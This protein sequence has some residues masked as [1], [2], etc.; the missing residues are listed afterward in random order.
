MSKIAASIAILLLAFSLPV[1]TQ[2]PQTAIVGVTVVDGNGGPPLHDGVVVISG[3]RIAAVGP[4]ASV[5]VPPGAQ[6]IDGTGRWLVPGFVDTNVHLSL[7]GGAGDRYESLVRYE[8]QQND[9]VLEA[10]Q[11]D[12]SH[13]ITTVR[14]SYGMLRPLTHVRDLIAAG[15]AIGPRIQA[16]GNIVGWSGPYS[17]SFSLTKPAGLTLFQEQM[18]DEVAQ[19]AGE[20]LMTMTPEQL[21]VAIDAYLDKGPDFI[22]YGGTSHFE[23]PTY[24]G[25]SPEAQKVI[26]DEAHRRGR[27][28]ETHATSAEGLRIAIDAGIDLIQHPEIIDD[29][30]I[31]DSLVNTIRDRRIVCSMLV[32]TITGE[33]WQKHLKDR[34]AAAKKRTEDVKEGKLPEHARTTF[35]QRQID[36]DLGKGLE[37]RRRSAEKL[38]RAG[39]VVTVGTDSYWAAAPELTRMP[40]PPNQDHGTGTILAIEGLVELGMTPSQ[41][42]VSATK[43]GAI[44]SRDQKDYGTIE[45]GKVAD[46]VLLSADPLAD[47]HN[48]EKIDRVIKSGRVIDRASLPEHRVLSK[49]PGRGPTSNGAR[50]FSRADALQVG[51]VAFPNSGAAAAQPAF[52]VG[53]AQLH[54]FEYESAAAWFR[55]AQRLDPGFAMAYWGEAMTYN[56]PVWMQQDRDAAVKALTR[57]GATEAARLAKAPTEREK[58]YLRAVD[59]LYGSGDKARRDFA[60]ADAMAELHRRYPDDPDA[61]AFY[62]LSLLGTAHAGRDYAIYMRAAAVLEPVFAAH[63]GHPGAAHYLIHSYDDP[64]H[65]PLGLPAARAYSKIAPSAAHAQ[66]MCS[67][68]FVALGMWDDVV[69]ANEAAVRVVDAARAQKGQPPSAC[70]HYNFWLEYGYLQ[71]GR[72]GEAKRVLAACYAAARA[73]AGGDPAA[74]DPDDSLAGSFA[75]MR[76]R[77]LIDTGDWT[78]EAAGWIVDAPK[79]AGVRVTNEFA[80]GLA[81]ARHGDVAPARASLA[82]LKEARAVLD[83]QLASSGEEADA[84]YGARAKILEE[85]LAATIDATQG[86]TAR[87]VQA[88]SVAAAEEARLPFEFG[89]PFVDKPSEELLGEVLLATGGFAEAR[90]AFERSLARAPQRTASLVGLMQAAQASGDRQKADS[91]RAQLLAIWHHADRIPPE[92]QR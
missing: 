55:D 64:V 85:Q 48:I 50:G 71:Q 23:E 33:A 78:G 77:Y 58:D 22:K 74:L 37:L 24:I 34:D 52:L 25:F 63:P 90:A 92:L 82:R 65:A 15:K 39:A 18:N 84:S 42:I 4:R 75:G 59:I 5:T 43:N 36:A 72:A 89:P 91:V 16:A 88:L 47:I 38:V 70:G 2:T 35:E 19:G 83:R 10:A 61:A 49:A 57:L 44:A 87:A 9:I 28:A 51:D 73:K 8:P 76:A 56:H 26:V 11:I 62:A 7:Y 40:K 12:L 68:I 3:D 17:I 20:E 14:D 60:Y 46:A 80:T 32:S 66:H 54:N 29:M 13:G 69:A 41:A 21:R 86:Q 1:S 67:H 45:P 31:P 53:L 27:G 81:A 30:E 6:V 79:Q